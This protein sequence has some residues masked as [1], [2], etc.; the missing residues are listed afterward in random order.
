[1]FKIYNSVQKF[2]KECIFLSKL[3]LGQPGR[4]LLYWTDFFVWSVYF[5]VQDGVYIIV[6]CVVYF[7]GQCSVYLLYCVQY[8][9]LSSVQYTLLYSVHYI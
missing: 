1:M 2:T 4:V 9:L 6:Q 5:I 3:F 7:T 8:T